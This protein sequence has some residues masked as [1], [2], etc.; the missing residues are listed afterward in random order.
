[1][2]VNFFGTKAVCEQL[3]LIKRGGRIVNV[4][5]G[6]GSQRFLKSQAIKE[7]FQVSNCGQ[8]RA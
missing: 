7:K 8:R 3:P 6:S 5:S 4:S 1:M 2:E